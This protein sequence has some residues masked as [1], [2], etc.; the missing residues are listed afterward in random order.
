[1]EE[2]RRKKKINFMYVNYTLKNLLLKKTK[3]SQTWWYLL[4]IP[5]LRRLRR[6]VIEFETSLGYIVNSYIVTNYLKQ[7]QKRNYNT[8]YKSSTDFR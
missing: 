7:Q 3:V 5:V 1:L 2:V 8:T 6:R 4:V